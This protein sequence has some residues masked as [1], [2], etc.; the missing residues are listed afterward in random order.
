MI[1]TNLVSVGYRKGKAL[2]Y[3]KGMLSISYIDVLAD[4]LWLWRSNYDIFYYAIDWV[5]R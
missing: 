1:G 2:C 4:L 3:G 5:S